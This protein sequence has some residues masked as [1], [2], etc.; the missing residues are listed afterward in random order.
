MQHGT[1]TISF[2]AGDTGRL[3]EV[4]GQ[5]IAQVGT[6][7]STAFNGGMQPVLAGYASK[8]VI[9]NYLDLNRIGD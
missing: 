7:Y 6:A 1:P 4:V 2:L 5:P 3:P 9:L 8:G